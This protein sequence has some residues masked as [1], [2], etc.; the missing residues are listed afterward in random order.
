MKTDG[1]ES[2][3]RVDH[4]PMLAFSSNTGLVNSRYV[5]AS[6]RSKSPTVDSSPSDSTSTWSSLTIISSSTSISS[7][8]RATPVQSQ[9]NDQLV[10]GSLGTPGQR[11]PG[12][13]KQTRKITWGG[14]QQGR[15][16]QQHPFEVH[17]FV[18]FF[19]FTVNGGQRACGTTAKLYEW[20]VTDTSNGPRTLTAST[21]TA[22]RSAS[23]HDDQWA[24]WR[25]RPKLTT[26]RTSWD[27]WP[28][29][30]QAGQRNFRADW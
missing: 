23:T 3:V 14:H 1:R 28:P 29:V 25:C 4:L 15:A 2:T 17:V 18:S 16:Q 6:V 7:S 5:S 8:A 22:H 30:G 19:Y 20:T 26:W 27:D 13:R 12:K 11:T 9:F 21:T 24:R 10:C